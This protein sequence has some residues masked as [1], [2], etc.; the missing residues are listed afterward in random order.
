[1]SEFVDKIDALLPRHQCQ[2]CGYDDC[3][4]Y[5]QAIAAGEADINRCSPGG[6]LV[7][8]ALAEMTGR[9]PKPLATDVEAV[10]TA[11][12]ARIDPDV[13]IGCTKCLPACPVDAIV[14]GPKHLHEVMEAA[15]TGCGLCIPPCPVDCIE[16]V[17]V[18]EE[19][20]ARG[21]MNPPA[22]AV[23]EERRRLAHRGEELRAR[24]ERHE[25]RSKATRK[26][27]KRRLDAAD[28]DD[29]ATRRAE[30]ADAVARVRTKRRSMRR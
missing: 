13:C 26:R 2:R 9:T 18:E 17:P 6:A 23:A 14:G 5:A 27:R 10:A 22:E 3:R 1:V 19:A 20:D 16:L 21:R 8:R 7:T 11:E 30:I 28:A 4:A 29:L 24:Y 12:V 25:T 15:C